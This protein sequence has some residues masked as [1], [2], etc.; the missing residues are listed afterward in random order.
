MVADEPNKKPEQGE[1]LSVGDTAVTNIK[2]GDN[3]MFQKN[4]NIQIEVNGEPLTLVNNLQILG[5][6]K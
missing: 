2:V 4:G 1:V 5:T 3:I 6:Y